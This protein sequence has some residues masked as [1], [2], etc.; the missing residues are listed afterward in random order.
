MA[1]SSTNGN[2]NPSISKKSPVL[3]EAK[4]GGEGINLSL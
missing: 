2:L 1:T 4:Q 3:L